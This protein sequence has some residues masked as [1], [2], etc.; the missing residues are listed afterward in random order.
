MDKPEQQS[1]E[2]TV[3]HA[4]AQDGKS[5]LAHSRDSKLLLIFLRHFG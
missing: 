2:F 3:S 1:F 4:L 5:L